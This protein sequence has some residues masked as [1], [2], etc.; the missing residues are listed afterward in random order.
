MAHRAHR[1]PATLQHLHDMSP[2]KAAR[3]GHQNRRLGR[4][5]RFWAY[6]FAHPFAPRG[7]VIHQDIILATNAPIFA[8]APAMRKPILEA[9]EASKSRALSTNFCPRIPRHLRD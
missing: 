5:P 2:N 7:A 8:A 9:P 3:P 1:I 4:R 6:L